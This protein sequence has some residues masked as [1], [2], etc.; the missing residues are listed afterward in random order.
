MEVGRLVESAGTSFNWVLGFTK[1]GPVSAFPL[2]VT[3]ILAEP[4][5]LPVFREDHRVEHL[6]GVGTARVH[7]ELITV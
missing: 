5:L 1:N 3:Q 6:A 4:P 7:G 2:C